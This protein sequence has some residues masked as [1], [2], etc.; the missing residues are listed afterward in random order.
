[1]ATSYRTGSIINKTLKTAGKKIYLRI[2][3]MG[4]DVEIT[5]R[6]MMHMM[7]DDPACDHLFKVTEADSW[8]IIDPIASGHAVI[9]FNDP[10]KS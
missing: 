9:M 1:M 6:V 7:E 4:V 10:Y 2:P 8:I 5:E 3:L